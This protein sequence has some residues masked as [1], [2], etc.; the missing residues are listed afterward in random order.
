MIWIPLYRNLLQE[1]MLAQGWC[2]SIIN[3]FIN[4]VFVSSLKYIVDTATYTAH[5]TRDC[6]SLPP[7]LQDQ[8]YNVSPNLPE[9]ERSV[10]T[11]KVPIVSFNENESARVYKLNVI[12][13]S[14]IILRIAFS[15][16]WADGLGSTTEHGRQNRRIS[17]LASTKPIGLMAQ[18]YSQAKAVLVLDG[19][20]QACPSITSLGLRGFSPLAGFSGSGPVMF[21]HGQKAR[22]YIYP[23]LS[24]IVSRSSRN[25][26]FYSHIH[27]A[28]RDRTL[29]ET[30][31][32][33]DL[34]FAFA[35][36]KIPSSN[37]MRHPDDMFRFPHITNL[38]GE[39]FR[40]IKW[41]AHAA[42]SIGFPGLFYGTLQTALQ[43]RLW[44]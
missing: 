7:Q 24:Q 1:D 11:G 32:S 12:K 4:T 30:M 27:G 38:A 39:L 3:Y 23:S 41:S 29:Q 42:Y 34:N 40:L 14:D 6:R 16:V 33:K 2:P 25:N 26:A 10:L 28:P 15:Y 19:T 17:A 18:T 20:L 21:H 43:T 36:Q 22:Y 8:C 5:H 9:I 13:G 35:V 44:Q 37:L 31:L